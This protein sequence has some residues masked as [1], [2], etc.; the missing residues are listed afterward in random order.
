M[1]QKTPW[2][3]LIRARPTKQKKHIYIYIYICMHMPILAT[4]PP[5]SRLLPPL[6]G[7][8]RGPR[9][10]VA[11]HVCKNFQKVTEKSCQG[12]FWGVSAMPLPLHPRTPERSPPKHRPPLLCLLRAHMNYNYIDIYTCNATAGLAVACRSGG[13]PGSSKFRLGR[14]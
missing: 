12:R 5:D 10:F 13:A 9:S 1:S 2:Q 6:G 14:C 3:S 8:L 4:Q 7:A 11:A